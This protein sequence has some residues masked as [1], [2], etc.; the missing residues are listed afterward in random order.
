LG[1]PPNY[2]NVVVQSFC[3]TFNDR[4]I[5]HATNVGLRIQPRPLSTSHDASVASSSQ[6][7]ICLKEALFI[8]GTPWKRIAPGKWTKSITSNTFY[9]VAS[10]STPPPSLLRDIE[11]GRTGKGKANEIKRLSLER[12]TSSRES[13]WNWNISDMIVADGMIVMT[14][15]SWVVG[16]PD[17]EAIIDGPDSQ[18]GENSGKQGLTV[19]DGCWALDLGSGYNCYG[20]LFDGRRLIC[21]G[22]CVLILFYPGKTYSSIT[23]V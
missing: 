19:E 22:V 8:H 18:S 20:L 4:H 10:P 14:N 5:F 13:R 7:L 21:K 2:T 11:A 16:I 15:G 1:V 3:F 12:G 17:Y 6:N 23:Y 9:L